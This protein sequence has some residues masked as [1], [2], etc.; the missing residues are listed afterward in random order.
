MVT[1]DLHVEARLVAYVLSVNIEFPLGLTKY[2][3]QVK[4]LASRLT[5][6]ITVHFNYS[7][8]I[9]DYNNHQFN[10]INFKRY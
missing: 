3:K 7:L 8:I 2:C 6:K 4:N 5:V 1:N 9:S 10:R